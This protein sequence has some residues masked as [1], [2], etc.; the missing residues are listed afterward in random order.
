M[1]GATEVKQVMAEC[2]YESCLVT[3]KNS[4]HPPPAFVVSGGMEPPQFTN[5]FPHWEEDEKAVTA[6]RKVGLGTPLPPSV[7]FVH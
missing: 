5:L 1:A 6:S 2:I 7:L 4:G 3:A